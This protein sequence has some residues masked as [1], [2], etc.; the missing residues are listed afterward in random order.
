MRQ[1]IIITVL[2]ITFFSGCSN[3]S[4]VTL[5]Q[6]PETNLYESSFDEL[7]SWESENYDEALS[8]FINSCQ[9][10]KTKH[11]YGDLC[12]K[13]T[14]SEN[15]KEF[16]QREFSVYKVQ[17]ED[18]EE[19]GLLTGYYEPSLK[20]SLLKTDFYIYP[21]YNTPKDLIIVDLSSIYPDLKNYRLRG[22]IE[23]NKLVP[24]YTR[25]QMQDNVVD[26]DVI[27]YTNS[28]I[29]LFFLEVQGSGRVILE[30]G[31]T[32][33]LG[34][35]NQNG[36]KYS[37]IGK[38][39]VSKGEIA[40]EDISLQTIR[41]WFKQNPSRVD[42][43]LNYNDSVVYFRE[44][45]KPASGSLG[46][47]L[48]PKR[49]VAVDRKYIPLG[50]MLFL[51]ATINKKDVSRIVMAEDTG[52]AIKGALRAD[53]FFGSSEWARESAGVLKS[54]LSLWMFLPKGDK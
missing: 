14:Q 16:L 2:I 20:G 27:C 31:E 5:P 19:K 33:Y 54:P 24:Y 28:K 7:P 23:G 44:K 22:K 9:S 40:L 52:G 15:S 48:T 17:S 50:S 13:A 47:I 51:D 34:F 49:S 12:D 3:V 26:A 10:K 45:T 42:E 18:E 39:L 6:I 29:D 21:I 37:S 25:E 4:K 41:E 53:M 35:A 1:T 8:S 30:N 11:I 32:I 36:H 43:V 46:V 38:Y